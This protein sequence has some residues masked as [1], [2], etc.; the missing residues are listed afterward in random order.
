MLFNS[1]DYLLFL[2]L[3]VILYW[4]I[5]HKFRTAL[6]IVASYFFYMKWKPI[7]GLL[8]FALTLVN[9]GF[10]LAI[11]KSDT[12][13]K[14]LLVL[15]LVANLATLAYFKYTYFLRDAANGVVSWFSSG[16]H[17]V[18]SITWE[19]LLPLGISFFVFEFIHYI[20]DVYKGHEPVK[21][22]LNFA[23]F[24]SFFPTQLAGPI[25]RYQDFVQQLVAPRKITSA[26][27]D[28]AIELIM[29]GLFKKVVLAD[30][31]AL[32]VN[33]GYAN[34]QL[35]NGPDMWL[36]SWAF[37]FQVYYDFSGY[38]DIARG[39]ALLF[40]YRVPVNF[41]LPYMASSIADFWRR[42]HISLSLWLRD[43]VFI[44][45]GGNK[46]GTWKNCLNLF[47]TMTLAGLWHGAAD[48]F[49]AF[50]VNIGIMLVIHR[51][52][53]TLV[54]KYAALNKIVET[55]AFHIFAI[56]FTFN[57]FVLA[58]ASFRAPSVPAGL[59]IWSKML[60]LPDLAK[61]A[62]DLSPTILRTAESPIFQIIP[63]L[64]LGCY[65]AHASMYVLG[66]AGGKDESKQQAVPM[67]RF[68]KP[69]YLAGLA[70]LL[71]LFSPQITPQF[72]YYQF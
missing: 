55:Q 52:W 66:R 6:L 33:R 4:L 24:A 26:D 57:T 18:P 28:E 41:N 38:T 30:N 68:L 7:Y 58:L 9:Y 3:T 64:L 2:P 61:G 44:P 25:K 27:F 69:A 72:I 53:R 13:K 10:G 5:P 35:L 62:I 56:F 34:Y 45:L 42:W 71:I 23:L 70:I 11:H 21:N 43:Y 14:Q 17:Q 48:H 31:I 15:A 40:G 36:C 19:I 20:V 32:V 29:I 47:I 8:L 51:A 59:E 12:K 46:Q 49:V 37:A 22:F 16:V 67:P 63:L 65:I 39:S 54:G 50:G 1:L 60:F